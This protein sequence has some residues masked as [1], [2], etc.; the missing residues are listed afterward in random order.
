MVREGGDMTFSMPRE[1][2]AFINKGCV[3][4]PVD[5]LLLPQTYTVTEVITKQQSQL[6]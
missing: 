1:D 3:L 2:G 5:S 4:R 6:L